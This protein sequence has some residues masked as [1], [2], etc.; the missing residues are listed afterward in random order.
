MILMIHSITAEP[1]GM[2][3]GDGGT[4]GAAQ[5]KWYSLKSAW[6]EVDDTENCITYYYQ[7]KWRLSL[8]SACFCHSWVLAE[9]SS[10]VQ[11]EEG[12]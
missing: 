10:A 4:T 5:L 2:P 3:S 7:P 1:S 9:D 12:P 8:L 11:G 6:R